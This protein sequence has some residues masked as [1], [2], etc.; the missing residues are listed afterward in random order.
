[1]PTVEERLA[2]LE[3]RVQEHTHGMNEFRSGVLR[4]DQRM[5]ALDLKIDRVREELGSRIDALDLKVDRFREEL[6]SRM[7]GL[8]ARVDAL[9]RKLDARFDSLDQ[10]ASRTFLWVVGVQMTVLLAVIGTLLQVAR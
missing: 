2:F 9:D 3:G 1:M 10:K 6:G 8:G 5:D 4:L 7:D